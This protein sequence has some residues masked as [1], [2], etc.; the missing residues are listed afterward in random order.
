MT[1][2]LPPQVAPKVTNLMNW[3]QMNVVPSLTN[4]AAHEG[5]DALKFVVELK[6]KDELPG[7]SKDAQMDI[8]GS[9]PVAPSSVATYPFWM[10]FQ[11][12]LAG[13]SL[14]NHYIVSRPT[15]DAPWELEKA[16][17]TDP[18]GHTIKEWPVK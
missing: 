12:V 6:D 17:R 14:T 7:V 13:D 8:T 10:A 1:N 5:Y 11:L 18:D 16:W 9:M 3:A 4:S 15:K 2:T